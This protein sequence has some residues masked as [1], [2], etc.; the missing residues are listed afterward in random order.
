MV[1]VGNQAP[2]FT[3]TNTK[4]ESVSLESFRGKKVVLAFYPGAFTGVCEKELCTFRDSLEAFN[5]MN[6]VVLGI[7]VDSP[8]SNGAFAEKTK[9]TFPLLSDYARKTVR[10]Y[11]VELNDFAKLPGYTA[12]QR[13]VFVLDKDGVVRYKWVAP[14]P[15]V[16]PSYD[17][18]K[19]AVADLG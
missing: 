10:D 5:G 18:V 2:S 15:G 14:N 3:L 6:A 17:E 4:R 8:F 11:G 7:S 13:A 19:K 9:V 1:D 16:E 12:A